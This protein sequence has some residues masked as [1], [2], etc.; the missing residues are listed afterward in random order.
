LTS[1]LVLAAIEALKLALFL[2]QRAGMTEEEVDRKFEA[3]KIAFFNRPTS[4]LK[5]PPERKVD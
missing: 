4:A 3:N 5:P 1:D 2:A